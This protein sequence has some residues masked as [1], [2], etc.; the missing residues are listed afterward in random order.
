GSRS[1]PADLQLSVS[2]PDGHSGGSADASGTAQILTSGLCW[3]ATFK[4]SPVPSLITERD[5][6]RCVAVNDEMLNLLGLS[7]DEVIGR[8]T[9]ALR[10]WSDEQQRAHMLSLLQEHGS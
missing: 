8:S 1:W 6:G 3:E 5:T 4:N 9:I 10:F 2:E 7:S